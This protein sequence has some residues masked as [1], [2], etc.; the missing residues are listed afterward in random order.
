MIF[1]LRDIVRWRPMYCVPTALCAISGITPDEAGALLQR[2]AGEFGVTIP[3]ELRNDYNINHWLRA[4]KLI[5][6]HWAEV[7]DLDGIPYPLR[8]TINERCRTWRRTS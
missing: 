1:D 6:G 2:A 4:I 5:G 7:E 8:P 3:G